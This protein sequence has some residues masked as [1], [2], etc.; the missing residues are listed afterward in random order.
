MGLLANYRLSLD[1]AA[2]SLHGGV[3]G[4]HLIG[5]AATKRLAA[6]ARSFGLGSR[7]LPD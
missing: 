6:L 4:T 2:I 3:D 1:E 7:I 5:E